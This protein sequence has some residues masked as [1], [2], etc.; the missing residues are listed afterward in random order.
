MKPVLFAALAAV[1]FVS[2]AVTPVFAQ[3]T[4]PPVFKDA[5]EGQ[6]QTTPPPLPAADP[7]GVIPVVPVKP[8]TTLADAPPAEPKKQDVPPDPCAGSMGDFDAYTVCQDMMQKIERMKKGSAARNTYYNPPPPEE[9]KPEE[10]PAD[11]A[12]KPEEKKDGDK[13]A[14]DAKKTDEKSDGKTD[15]KTGAKTDTKTETKD[16]ATPAAA[17]PA[18]AESPKQIGNKQ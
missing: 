8:A 6:G 13:T 9:K 11:P 1:I 18:P 10:K 7:N 12:A 2:G 17:T 3:N 16:A 5:N 4:A 15:E 14:A